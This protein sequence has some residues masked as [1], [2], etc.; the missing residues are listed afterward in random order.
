MAASLRSRVTQAA[1]HDE[2]LDENPPSS[3]DLE[4]SLNEHREAFEIQTIQ[5]R[6]DALTQQHQETL[7]LHKLRLGY[8]QDIFRLVCAW[9]CCVVIG[10][11]LA[12]FK[13]WGF[14]LSD[15][16]L[17]AFITS[18]TV[19]VVG[20]FIVV[21]KWMYAPSAKQGTPLTPNP[22]KKPRNSTPKSA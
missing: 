17:I 11:M 3:P 15:T 8:A 6:V 14:S 20:L 9:L 2:P 16:V 1:S 12:G 10:V 21:A 19:N 22:P 7:D 5:L 18:T 13:A 4:L